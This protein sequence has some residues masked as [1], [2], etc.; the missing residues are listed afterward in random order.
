MEEEEED[1]EEDQDIKE[2]EEN[3]KE[4]KHLSTETGVCLHSLKWILKDNSGAK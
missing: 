3:S 2:E 1:L 4:S